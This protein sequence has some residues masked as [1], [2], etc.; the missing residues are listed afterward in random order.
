MRRWQEGV[1]H[2][3]RQRPW[4]RSG[5]AIV[6]PTRRS[7]E[8][9]PPSKTEEPESG[10]FPLWTAMPPSPCLSMAYLWQT[11]SGQTG[12]ASNH[13]IP[14]LERGGLS[15]SRKRDTA[16]RYPP[17]TLRWTTIV[18][19]VCHGS[20]RTEQQSKCR[21]CLT[22]RPFPAGHCL[23]LWKWPCTW[24]S[25]ARHGKPP[26]GRGQQASDKYRPPKKTHAIQAP[27]NQ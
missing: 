4:V 24:Q 8:R 19:S 1:R 11:L 18:P 2:C 21:E 14:S 15:Q 20:S 22:W 25:S 13:Q 9:R 26:D 12:N 16:R 23:A 5:R 27:K 6:F 3:R 10:A 17:R 7:D